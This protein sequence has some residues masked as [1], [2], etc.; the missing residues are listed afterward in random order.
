M[1]TSREHELVELF[2]KDLTLC[3]IVVLDADGKVLTWNAG[4][5]QLWG[6][7]EGEIV[8]RPWSRLHSRSDVV[9]AQSAAA[10]QDA[11][12]WGRYEATSRLVH[13][14][15]TGFEA[16][17]VVRPLFD[18]WKKLAGFGL[19]AHGPGD[20]GHASAAASDGHDGKVVALRRKINVLVVDDDKLVCEY[21]AA[22]LRSLGYGVVMATSGAEALSVLERIDDID[23]LFTDVVMPGDIGGRVLAANATAMRPGLKVLYA[24]GYFEGALVGKGDLENHARFLAKPYLKREL[25]QKIEEALN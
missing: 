8:G 25:A 6:Y 7:A 15:G 17:T 4:A 5:A 23:L 12:Q 11:L 2:V 20:P 18:P 21:A 16:K 13:K 24:S 3:A 10:L 19:L 14:D 1:V 9:T 22:E